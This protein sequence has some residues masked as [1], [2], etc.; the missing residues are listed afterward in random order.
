MALPA[1]ITTVPWAGVWEIASRSSSPSGSVAGSGISMDFPSPVV[2]RLPLASGG[3]LEGV[4]LRKGKTK[5]HYS[6]Q[7]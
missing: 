2:G 6:T 7:R 3:S 4:I 1:A 5:G